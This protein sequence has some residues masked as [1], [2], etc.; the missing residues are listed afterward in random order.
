LLVGPVVPWPPMSTPE[1]TLED[2]YQALRRLT[3]LLE[4]DPLSPL[5]EWLLD[6]AESA[7]AAIRLK[8]T[9]A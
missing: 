9:R 7:I 5:D 1:A 2:A 8:A 6:L 3:E 4:A